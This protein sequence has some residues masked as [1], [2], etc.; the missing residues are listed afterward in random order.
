MAW[1]APRPEGASHVAIRAYPNAA[2]TIER[3]GPDGTFEFSIVGQQRNVLEISGATDRTGADRGEAAF[4]RVPE[5]PFS[6]EVY[7]CCFEG[8]ASQG[9]CQTTRER[10]IQEDR[11]DGIFE[12]PSPQTG[13]IRCTTDE[14]CGF[15]EGE[16]LDVDLSRI[17]ITSPDESGFVTVSGFVDPR[18][19][20]TL[21]NR[22]LSG[23]GQ[24]QQQLRLTA[25]SSDVGDFSFTNVLARGDDEL[26]L[27]FEELTGLRSPRVSFRVDDAQLAGLD[28]TGAFAWRALQDGAVGQVA[29]QIAPYGVDGRGLCPD[30]DDDPQTCF[31]GGLTHSMVTIE[32]LRIDGRGASDGVTW[33]PTSTSAE[34][35][36]IWGQDGD[37][38]AGPLDV[39]L[40]IDRSRSAESANLLQNEAAVSA[41]T[42]FLN[43]L[44]E[45][46]RVGAV[47]YGTG[48]VRLGVT[49]DPTG[50]PTSTGMFEGGAERSQ[51]IAAVQSA[52]RQAGG[53]D[54]VLFSGITEA[55]EMLRDSANG[56][57]IVV[58][59]ADEQ[60]GNVDESEIAFFEA[61][62]KVE[63]VTNLSSRPPTRVDVIG[64]S[65]IRSE[66]FEDLQSITAFTDGVYYDLAAVQS[67]NINQLELVLSDVRSTLSGSFLLLYDI[68]IPEGV[69]KAARIEFD[70][71]MNGLETTVPYSG[72]LRVDLAAN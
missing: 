48:L 6:Q 14:E 18:S 42:S 30:H 4:L 25:L 72:L 7:V 19:L 11:V 60:A 21:Q 46:D 17:M 9:T 54:S 50:R 31:S 43:G 5:I 52:M 49:Y 71:R 67:G 34:Y 24:P 10:E 37:V 44:R 61:L 58:I 22:G 35:P 41:V 53:G 39:V 12:C 65:L 40:V 55:A 27:Q 2:E 66:K 51:L 70:A 29:I 23:I 15:E 59:T 32:N 13:R 62:E 45:R 38:R 64:V 47:T 57:R 1:P 26:L 3:V 28:V 69:G 8:G 36:Q 33:T 68:S 56:G 16:Y 20:V 63:E